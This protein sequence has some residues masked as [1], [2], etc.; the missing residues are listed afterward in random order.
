M[1]LQNF[2]KARENMVVSQL[3]PSG[4]VSERVMAAFRA[5]PREMF[6]PEALRGVCYLD[7]DIAIGRGRCLVEPLV[8]AMMVQDANIQEGDKVLDI[9]GAT[10]YSAAILAQLS[11]NV[12]A[13]EQE[14]TLLQEADSHWKN[15]GVENNITSMVGDHVG[16]F[17]TELPYKAIFVVGAVAD[18]SSVLLS[19][20][21]ED[22]TLYAVLR[23]DVDSQ[24]KVLAV[25]RDVSGHVTER[26]LGESGCAYIPGFEPKNSFTF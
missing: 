11:Q 18:I 16:G 6:V 14:E 24:G 13:L 21:A 15:L 17:M 5:V 3:Q 12:V 19:Q 4:V 9:G 10:G 8:L 20:L 7:D 25:S 2:E 23:P 26:L 22:G 1:T